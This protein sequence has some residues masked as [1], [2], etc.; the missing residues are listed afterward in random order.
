[1]DNLNG[2]RSDL[3][4]TTRFDK[5]NKKIYVDKYQIN[6][7]IHHTIYFNNTNNK[8]KLIDILTKEITFFLNYAGFNNNYFAFIIGLG[9]EEHTADA[10]GPKTIKK[11]NSNAYLKELDINIDRYIATLEPGVLGTTGIDTKRIVESV[12][13]EIKPDVAIIIDAFVTD[14]INE[15]NH[16]ITINNNGITPGSGVKGLNTEINKDTLGI[17]VIV[18]GVPTAVEIKKKKNSY[19]LTN[20]NIDQYIINLSDIISQALNNTFYK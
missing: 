2:C 15:L 6:N 9:N 4:K 14:D 11:V 19:L 20:N 16:T 5:T 10:I 1:M 13:S 8:E 7:N 12:A 17:P 18:I 3:I